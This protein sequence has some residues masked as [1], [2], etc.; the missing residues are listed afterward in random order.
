MDVKFL[1]LKAAYAELQ[2]GLDSAHQR[3]MNSG[4]YVLGPEVEAF[5]QEFATYCGTNHS[6]GV[7]NGLDALSLILRAYG[8]T[9]DDEIIVPATTFI[10]T[11]LAVTLAGSRIVPVE[12]AADTCNID[13]ARIE[14]AITSR[15]RVIMAVH[16]YGQPADMDAINTIAS[17]HELKVVEDAAQ[18]HGAY[19]KSRRAGNLS[20]AA[21]FSFYPGKNLGALG[22]G[23]AVTT[24]D[25]DLAATICRMRNYGSTR[26]YHH[27]VVGMNSRLDELQAAMLRVKLAVLDEWNERRRNIA[28]IYRQKLK[29]FIQLVET[30]PGTVPVWHIFAIRTPERG[31][32]QEYLKNAGIQTM[33]HYPVPPHQ[34]AAYKHLGYHPEAF[35]ISNMLHNSVL[36]LPIGPHVTVEE[37]EYVADSVNRFFD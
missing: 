36:S 29:E 34:Q 25:D 37:A 2:A 30:P 28:G 1:D 7:G 17:R 4:W 5:E 32:L 18:A 24:N 13:P 35:P 19:Y 9:A 16:L 23:G 20:D 6:I 26:K 33:I 27:E 21:G 15:T 31:A 12:P 8:I 10:A 3:V 11:W 22:D 14:E